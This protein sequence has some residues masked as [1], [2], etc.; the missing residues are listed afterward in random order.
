MSPGWQNAQITDGS[1]RSGTEVR[2]WQTVFVAKG[3]FTS[4]SL[5]CPSV[6]VTA[7]LPP[8]LSPPILSATWFY[9]PD[10]FRVHAR[11]RARSPSSLSPTQVPNTWLRRIRTRDREL[12]LAQKVTGKTA[13]RR[14]ARHVHVWSRCMAFRQMV[15]VSLHTVN[16][17]HSW[18]SMSLLIYLAASPFGCG[19]THRQ[20]I[21]PTRGGRFQLRRFDF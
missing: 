2:L 6:E 5:F 11:L 15:K 3:F 12:R 8:P 13:A 4:S 17:P 16:T 21:Q 20:I 7:L 14:S 9:F 10:S 18:T 1:Q 19:V